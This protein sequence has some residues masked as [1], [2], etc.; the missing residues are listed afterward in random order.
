MAEKVFPGA[1][2]RFQTTAALYRG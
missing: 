2:E 1:A